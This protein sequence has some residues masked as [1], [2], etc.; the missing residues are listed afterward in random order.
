MM[1]VC[2]RSRSTPPFVYPMNIV[3]CAC[4]VASLLSFTVVSQAQN[5]LATTGVA[6]SSAVPETGH[7]KWAIDGDPTTAWSNASAADEKWLNVELPGNS[8]VTKF[9]VELDLSAGDASTSY[10]FQN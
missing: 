3:K 5:N 9:E 10:A 7:P 1:T 6:T 2:P 8:E 4:F